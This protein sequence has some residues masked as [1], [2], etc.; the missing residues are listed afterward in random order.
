[1]VGD[2]GKGPARLRVLDASTQPQLASEREITPP[3]LFSFHHFTLPSPQVEASRTFFEISLKFQ[4]HL[5]FSQR[6]TL[7]ELLS[8]PTTAGEQNGDSSAAAGSSSPAAAAGVSPPP[9]SEAAQRSLPTPFLTKTY[10]LV[11]D[12]V[13]DDVISWNEDG[14]TF[15][16][17][18]PAEFARDL[19]PKYFKHNN[20]SSFV[21]QLNTYGFRKIVPD[22]WEFAN[23]CFRKG[24]KRLLC[25]IHRRKVTTVQAQAQAAAPV[26]I[27]AAAIPVA[28]AV[29][30]SGSANSAEEQVLSSNSSPGP[31]TAPSTSGSGGAGDLTEENDRLRK[32]NAKLSRELGQ[33]KKMC[34]NILMLMSRYAATQN[35]LTGGDAVA[36][37][38]E[39]APVLDLM[40]TGPGM[41]VDEAD[42][43]PVKM[44]EVNSPKIFGFSLGLKRSREDESDGTGPSSDGDVKMEPLDQQDPKDQTEDDQRP[45]PIYRPRPVYHGF[46]GCNGLKPGSDQI[47][48][49]PDGSG[50][51]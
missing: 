40:P 43:E 29:N 23:D 7:I 51:R 25:D 30:R 28:V 41:L 32:E 31:H 24:E 16:V 45:W 47:R 3:F 27:A 38:M 33:M 19:L 1:M 34:N 48:P 10:Q 44:E 49:D 18:R 14:S 46:K 21:R 5:H 12:P 39:A 11:D 35:Q 20:F 15:I 17:W 50:L 13:V 22:R 6:P 8:R 4:T 26:T 42:G 2:R 37:M 36:G 9:T